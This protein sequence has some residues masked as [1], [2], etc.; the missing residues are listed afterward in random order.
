MRTTLSLFVILLLSA[1]AVAQQPTTSPSA[2]PDQN[3]AQSPTR[4]DTGAAQTPATPD[5]PAQS[6]AGSAAASQDQSMADA[7][8]D[9]I[10]GCLGGHDPNYTV[11]AKD[12]TVYQLMVPAG[13]DISAL[14]QHIGESVAVQG[15]VDKS[16]DMAS[17]SGTQS[18]AVAGS[19]NAGSAA[20]SKAIHAR[21]IRRG[22]G[23]C[24]ASGTSNPS[25]ASPNS[26]SSTTPPP[27]STTPPPPTKK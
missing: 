19:E 27:S 22:T 23:T 26:G 3:Q 9:V 24:P 5:A 8:S 14:A 13:A 4:P 25:S 18:G 11:T 2:T 21:R 10:E 7:G 15:S 17:K 6:Q 16:S 12:G 1:F 20:G